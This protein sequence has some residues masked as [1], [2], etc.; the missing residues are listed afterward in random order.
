MGT[1]ICSENT[2]YLTPGNL[3][4]LLGRLPALRALF[5]RPRFLISS[6]RIE[7]VPFVAW[8]TE[9]LKP[10]GFV[11]IG[12]D[13][14]VLYFAI[15][16]IAQ[17]LG[18]ETVCRAFF[19]SAGF[20]GGPAAVEAAGEHHEL[21]YSAQ[22]KVIWSDPSERLDEFADGSIDLLSIDATRSTKAVTEILQVRQAKLS[23][24]AIVLLHGTRRRNAAAS[25]IAGMRRTYPVL[26]FAHA[27]GLAVVG[28]GAGQID[29]LRRLFDGAE[30][31]DAGKAISELFAR[32]GRTCRDIAVVAEARRRSREL[33]TGLAERS[34]SLNRLATD[35]ERARGD[36]EVR[37]R[38]LGE[39]RATLERTAQHFAAERGQLVERIATLQ[40]WRG[41]LEANLVE[42]AQTLREATA[43][44]RQMVDACHES[45]LALLE[46]QHQIELLKNSLAALTGE[47]EDHR[48]AGVE[49]AAAA[50]KA[51]LEVAAA[52]AA[53]RT[54]KTALERATDEI[55]AA[56]TEIARLERELGRSQDE[57]ADGRARLARLEDELTRARAE[58]DAATAEIADL[59][60]ASAEAASRAGEASAA[61][62]TELEREQAALHSTREEIAGIRRA[63]DDGEAEHAR[64]QKALAARAVEIERLE[65]RQASREQA[66]AEHA[67]KFEKLTGDLGQL[68]RLIE[69]ERADFRRERQASEERHSKSIAMFGQIVANLAST[70]LPWRKAA[71]SSRWGR[72]LIEAGLFDPAWY[73]KNNPDVAAA[74]VDPIKHYLSHGAVE[75]RQPRPLE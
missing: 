56:R 67:E 22:S 57:V 74:G 16:Q 21:Y 42:T 7:H 70:A 35:L 25:L 69:S 49:A 19:A 47:V 38:E 27:G 58:T 64:L 73:L 54:S 63:L 33:E 37:A 31:E 46:R 39:V 5:V 17:Q 32:L 52:D 71:I 6:D 48:R 61:L 13:S 30:K 72:Y 9:T 40:E 44:N 34:Q 43:E 51:G 14:V 75:G 3:S 15:C 1:S 45:E 68:T 41:R 55:E 62:R 66:L 65:D 26:E 29:P 28:V 20:E 12:T 11:E 60:S 4:D 8:L 18:I 23:E 50:E 2:T 53:A 59:R 10:R 24:R 36:Q